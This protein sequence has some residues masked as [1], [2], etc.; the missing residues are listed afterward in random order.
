MGHTLADIAQLLEGQE[1][2][3]KLPVSTVFEGLYLPGHRL[4]LHFISLDHP[5]AGNVEPHY[6]SGLSDLASQQQIRIIHLW[7]DVYHNNKQ[8][9][10]ARILSLI[11]QRLRIHARQTTVVRLDQEQ[12]AVFLNMHHLQQ[13]TGTYYKYGLQYKGELVA[14]ATFSKS[15]IM[16]DGVV[17]YRSYELVR[18]ASKQGTTVT[19]G[20]GKLLRHFTDQHHPA[21]IMTYADRDWSSG[22]GYSKLGFALVETTPPQTFYIH[23][24]QLIRYPLLRLP[25]GL[26]Q[27][28]MTAKGYLK[29]Y[30]SGNL[31]Y[32]LDRRDLA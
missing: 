16:N 18:F 24:E 32:I 14:V 28:E 8:L 31:K 10:E 21:H 30:N 22:S 2:E 23:R 11:G 19:G 4:Q 6:F 12:A 17:P 20:L 27:E 26:T 1:T 13:S 25:D 15:R 29:I 7:S 5:A 3:Q 9:A